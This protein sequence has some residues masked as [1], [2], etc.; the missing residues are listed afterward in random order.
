MLKADHIRL[1]YIN[2]D[3]QVIEQRG[4]GFGLRLYANIAN[5]GILWRANK[6]NID[7][8]YPGSIPAPKTYAIGLQATF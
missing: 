7:P 5:L 4:K 3:Y 8:D 2:M 1:Q 6:E